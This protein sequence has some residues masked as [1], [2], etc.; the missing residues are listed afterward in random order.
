MQNCNS[1][2]SLA[3]RGYQLVRPEIPTNGIENNLESVNPEDIEDEDNADELGD[4][5]GVRARPPFRSWCR[6]C[7]MAAPRSDHT[8]D[9][10]RITMKCL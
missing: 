5:G 6:H 8:G 1:C 3:A 10:P 7:V 9:E 4:S 2:Q